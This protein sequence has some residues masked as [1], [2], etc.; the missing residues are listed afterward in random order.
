[1]KRKSP[2][3]SGDHTL[4]VQQ[5]FVRHQQAVLAYVLSIEP[6]LDDAQEILQETFLTV[7]RKADTW[8]DGTNF[9][10]WVC[11]IGR[12]NTLHYQRTRSRRVAR[13]DDD[14]VELLHADEAEDFSVFERHVA[15]LQSCLE[16]L[17]P[18]VRELVRLRYH[19]GRM[20]EQI[21]PA[22]GWTA[23]AVRVA[24]TRARSALRD[25]MR[26]KLATEE[27]R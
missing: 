24:L 4:R 27:A 22:V 3:P 16:R 19:S 15:I 21:A 1:M 10:A 11:T 13:L 2:S 14:V 17:T 18:R 25:C 23:N 26:P 9:L 8:T 6:S 7:S 12:Y 20:P 5:L